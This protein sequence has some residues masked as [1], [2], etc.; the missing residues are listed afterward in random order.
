MR[1]KRFK[2]IDKKKKYFINISILIVAAV[3]T[4][5]VFVML[6]TMIEWNILSRVTDESKFLASQQGELINKLMNEQFDKATTISSMVENGLSFSDEKNHAVLKQI[7][8]KNKL[9]MLAYADAGGD[10]VTYQGET[11]G[12]IKDRTYFN[13]VITGKKENVCQYLPTTGFGNDP[14]VIFSTAVYQQHKI[15]G[16]LFFSK[17][18]TVLSESLFQQSMF[19]GNESSLIVD[20]NGNILVKNK[21]AKE[22]Y[23]TAE[24]IYE[25]YSPSE[26]GAHEFSGS[27]NGSMVLGKEKDMVLAYSAIGQNDWYLICLIDTDT[28]RSTYA[29]NLI[30]IQHSIL[31]ACGCYLLGIA[32]FMLLLAFQI[33]ENKKKYQV[34]RNQYERILSLLEKMKCMI[35]EYDIKTEKLTTNT[36]FD[37]AFG[38]GIEDNF[39]LRIQE[40]KRKHPEF[41]FDG[42]VRELKYAIENK[43]TTSFDSIYCENETTYK[44]LSIVMMPI[45]NADGQVVNVLGSVRETSAEHHQLKEKVDMFTQIPGG[46]HRCYLS[47][48]IHLDYAGEKLCKMLGYTVEEFDKKVGNNYTEIIVKEDRQKFIDFVNEA[49]LSPGVRKCQYRVCCKNGDILSVLDTMESIRND[50]GVMRGYSVVVDVSEYEKRQNIARQELEELEKKLE[51]VRVENSTSQMQPHFLYNALSSIREVVIQNPQYAS[52]LIYDFMVYLRACIKTMQNGE[53]ISIFQEVDNIKAYTNIEIMRMGERLHV[54]YDI[55]SKDFEI[56]PLSIQ[57]L[58]ENAIRHGIYKRG[59]K[60]GTVWIQTETTKKYNVITI[61]DDGVGFDYQ[62]VRDE[63]ESGKRDSIGLDNAMFRLKKGLHAEVIIKSKIGVGTIVKINVPMDKGEN[64]EGYSS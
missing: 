31:F 48:P 28:A 15:G 4:T 8:E 36:L 25:I 37:K 24:N 60:G 57:P 22:K 18:I 49:S 59:T 58:V 38:Y 51:M 10:V 3:I 19:G 53:L 32:Y 23:K 43:V 9:C 2:N 13:D 30:S 1:K 35:L 45:L 21:H 62:K 26:I 29:K 64:G 63:V 61:R 12:N 11:I 17:E 41:D 6:N 27:K 42:L 34:Y 40:Y 50:S 16:V 33:K 20:S 55:Q 14:R 44:M 56:A 52:D 47:D 46:T 5:F 39:F 7:V 54:V